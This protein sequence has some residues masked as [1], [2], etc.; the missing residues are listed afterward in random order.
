MRYSKLKIMGPS[1]VRLVQLIRFLVTE[2]TH[3]GSNPRFDICVTFMI[4][5]SFSGR[6]RPHRQ[7]GALGDQ[8]RESQDQT[9]SV[10]QMC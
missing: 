1:R 8:L 3:S 9:G 6:R 2:L 4:N 10:F 5:Y 7:R